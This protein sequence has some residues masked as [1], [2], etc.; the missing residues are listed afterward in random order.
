M[1][2]FS[3]LSAASVAPK[4]FREF[5]LQQLYSNYYITNRSATAANVFKIQ[6]MRDA[7]SAVFRGK[8]D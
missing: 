6:R 3:C 4:S 1:M 2:G 8:I 7:Q 5:L